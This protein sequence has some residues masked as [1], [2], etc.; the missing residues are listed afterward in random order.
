[1]AQPG[2]GHHAPGEGGGARARA[3][4]AGPGH[5]RRGGARSSDS[6]G[7]L[8]IVK[9]MQFHLGSGK[10]GTPRTASLHPLHPSPSLGGQQLSTGSVQGTRDAEEAA[11]AGQGGRG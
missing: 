10:P 1:M 6:L 8:S 5:P 4:G 11:P 3:G 9:I 7:Q 2:T